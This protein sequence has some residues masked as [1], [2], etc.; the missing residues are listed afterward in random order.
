MAFRD[1][2]TRR[3]G[4]LVVV[5]AEGQAGPWVLLTDRPPGEVGVAPLRGHS[6]YGLRAWVEVG[7]RALKGVGWRWEHTRRTDPDRVARHPLRGH[8]WLVLAV[9]TLW[10]VAT[11][12]R[13]EDAARSRRPPSRLAEPPAAPASAPPARTVSVFRRGL[14]WLRQ[15]VV[16]GRVWQRLWLAPEPWP[17]IPPG[18]HLTFH[19]AP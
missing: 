9:A 19:E 12:T 1:R 10:V 13:A 8:G 17:A 16:T 7:F 3:A 6:W 15:Q 11:G 18:L 5:W 4:T 14:A 2:A